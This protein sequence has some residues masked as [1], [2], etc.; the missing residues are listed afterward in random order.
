MIG[1]CFKGEGVDERY[2]TAD[3]PAPRLVVVTPP[4]DRGGSRTNLTV[5]YT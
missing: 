4:G 2:S 3:G 5:S 1:C